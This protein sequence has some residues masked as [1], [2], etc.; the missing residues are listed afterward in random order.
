MKTILVVGAALIGIFLGAL[1]ARTAPPSQVAQVVSALGVDLSGISIRD[2]NPIR[3]AYDKVNTQIQAGQSLD[4]LGFHPSATSF[5]MPDQSDWAKTPAFVSN[6]HNDW[7]S[8]VVAQTRQFNNHMED[9]RNY[10]RNPAGRH[11]PAP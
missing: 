8:N 2:L 7:S 1:A 6:V 11:G 3:A 10:A 9:I 4:D 5:K